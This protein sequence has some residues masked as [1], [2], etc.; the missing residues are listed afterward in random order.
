MRHKERSDGLNHYYCFY[1]NFYQLLYCMFLDSV[2]T[3][4]SVKVN[5]YSSSYCALFF[6]VTVTS[7]YLTA[8][9]NSQF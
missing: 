1:W 6:L 4:K 8:L 3:L 5:G 2:S 9:L 7:F